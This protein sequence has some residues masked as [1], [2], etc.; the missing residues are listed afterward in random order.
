M[1]RASDLTASYEN[2]IFLSAS[3][4]GTWN[5]CQRK[6]GFSYLDR[7]KTPS[8][9]SA[10]LGQRVHA[11][12]EAWL[13]DGVPF[14]LS[15]EEG[16]IASSGLQYLPLP[17]SAEVEAGFV[18]QTETAK[19]RGFIDARF[20]ET[21][22]VILDHKTTSDLRWAKT[23][24][25]LR[26]DVQATLYA[27]EA[28]LRTGSEAVELRWIYYTTRK[29]Y[30][31][32]KVSLVVVKDEIEKNFDEI[33]A[34]AA[35]MLAAYRNHKSGAELPPSPMACGAYGGCPYLA[36]KVCDLAPKDMLRAHL[37]SDSQGRH[38]TMSMSLADKLKERKTWKPH[39]DY[40]GYEYNAATN[41]TRPITTQ[42]HA[43]PP[44]PPAPPAP[45]MAAPPAPPAPPAPAM[46]APPA[47]PA[48]PAAAA[49]PPP[50]PPAPSAP[51]APAMATPP[52][53]PA[54]H[55]TLDWGSPSILPPET[56]SN[57]M[58]A[59]APIPAPVAA[60]PVDP[61]APVPAPET[62]KRASKKSDDHPPADPF[63]DSHKAASRAKVISS[64]A[65]TLEA[66]AAAIRELR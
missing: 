19:Y 54:P 59:P 39:P 63:A 10:E 9:P 44:A 14:D 20:Q 42:N 21:L 11:V 56:P 40:P 60:A 24:E 34:V 52:A 6:W 5:Q 16:Q 65:D 31:S 8:H 1:T 58:A 46:A 53:P 61:P 2:D 49:P 64:L 15:T 36:L 13:K 30:K 47:P 32:R 27:A 35:Q 41:E 23:E 12:L 7:I 4:I 22:P 57:P 26:K 25:T 55:G 33:D 48:P 51:P 3:Q 43:A 37:E 62:K 66:L 29:P 17:G 28:M 45:A 50:A 38:S 18:V